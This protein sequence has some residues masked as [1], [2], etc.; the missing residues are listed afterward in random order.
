M[1]TLIESVRAIVEQA[2]G[3]SAEGLQAHVVSSPPNPTLGDLSSNLALVLAKQV[4]GQPLT[5]ASELVEKLK[6]H[7]DIA[8]ITVAPPGFINIKLSGAMLARAM[9]QAVEPGYGLSSR[10][11][12]KRARVEFVSANPTG[13]LHIGNARGG[14]LGDT[15]ANVLTANGYTV[16]REYIHN[17]VGGQVQKLGEAIVGTGDQ[18]TGGYVEELRKQIDTKN[19]KEAGVQAVAILF[20][21]IMDDCKAMGIVFDKIYKESDFKATQTQK[22]LDKLSLKEHEGA[23]WFEVSG[24]RDTV[25]VRSTGEPTYFAND[26]AYHDLKFSEG[27]DVVIDVLGSNHHGH[28]PKLQKVI[29]DLGYDEKRFKVVLYQFVRVKRGAEVVKMSK[30]AGT[31]VTAREV[32]EEVGKDAF[33][34]FMLLHDANTHMDFD[35]E[36]AKKQSKDNPVYYVQYAGARIH[37]IL[38]KAGKEQGINS[39][40]ELAF[41]NPKIRQLVLGLAA[42]PDL[43]ANLGET[44]EVHR[45]SHYAMKT[46][47]LFHDF[48]ESVPVLG[49]EGATREALLGLCRAT[50]NVLEHCLTLMGVSTPETM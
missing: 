18:Y 29:K 1:T 27:Y 33:R 40:S 42:Y 15:I 47:S 45:L 22:I 14:P 23:R 28:V 12:G 6:H 4:Q 43:V 2:A 50:M 34:F 10:F 24:V 20:G 38:A 9:A 44:L 48:Y 8:S 37:S 30:R 7:A 26:I 32:L 25:V 5:I 39:S 13:P 31:F 46:A 36:L 16:L 3:P 11:K 41:D 35:L 21:E 49:S 19:P 17:D